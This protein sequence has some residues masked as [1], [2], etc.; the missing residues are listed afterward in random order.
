MLNLS[1]SHFIGS[2]LTA[3]GPCFLSTLIFHLKHPAQARSTGHASESQCPHG[4]SYQALMGLE[5]PT[6]T[7]FT[8]QHPLPALARPSFLLKDSPDTD[9]TGGLYQRLYCSSSHKCQGLPPAPLRASWAG[10]RAILLCSQ[11]P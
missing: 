8:S 6:T 2:Q 11:N 10:V 3:Q 4:V 1:P 9:R 7:S 5:I